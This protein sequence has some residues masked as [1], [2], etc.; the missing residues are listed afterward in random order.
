MSTH[1]STPVS[2]LDRLKRRDDHA[3]WDRF[4]Q[5]YTPLLFHWLR[6][7]GLGEHDAADLV[8]DIFTKLIVVMPNFTYQPSQSF[9][10]WLRTIAVNCCRDRLKKRTPLNASDVETHAFSPDPLDSFIEREY[11]IQLANRA[12]QVLRSDFQP[13]TWQAVWDLV[14]E[15]Q[16]AAEVAARNGMTV[17][18]VYAAKCRVLARLRRELQGL[19]H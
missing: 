1:A 9:H 10:G 6:G 2:L 15:D 19:W 17:Q 13:Q 16:P 11:R 4:V 7:A 12:M 5:I 14:V 8:Q 3:A 18:A